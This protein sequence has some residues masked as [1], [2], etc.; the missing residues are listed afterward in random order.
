MAVL[1]FIFSSAVDLLKIQILN[2]KIQIQDYQ[3]NEWNRQTYEFDIHWESGA[4]E[5]MEA[6]IVLHSFSYFQVSSWSLQFSIVE[7]PL[8]SHSNRIYIIEFFF[9]LLFIYGI[10][11]LLLTH[12][13]VHTHR[14]L[15]NTLNSVYSYI[16]TLTYNR[17]MILTHK[18]G[19]GVTTKIAQEATVQLEI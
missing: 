8:G 15:W 10:F 19:I 18:H 12:V 11:S 1:T 16:R 4:T 17:I 2:L 13:H 14:I 3:E 6:R 9:F 7:P 5:K